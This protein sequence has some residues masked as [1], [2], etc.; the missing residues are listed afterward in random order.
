M[1]ADINMTEKKMSAREKIKL[2]HT[3]DFHLDSPFS[4]LDV[5]RSDERRVQL[6]E[7]FCAAVRRAKTD[8]CE[9]ILISGDLFDCGYVSEETVATVFDALA[10]CQIPTVISPGNHDP[11]TAGGVYSKK[12]LPSNVF[13][14]SSTELSYF[15]R[16]DLGVRVYGYAFVSEKYGEDPLSGGVSL[17]ERMI[18]ILC[19]HGDIY[20]PISTYASINLAQLEEIGFDYVALGHIHKHTEP[21]RLGKTVVSY[22]G[23]P[24]G[25]SF[26]EC[27]FGGALEVTVSH[28]SPSLT[29]NVEVKRV[30]LSDRRYLSESLDVSG[31]ASR[32][33]VAERIREYVKESA[34]GEETSLRLTLV[35]NVAPS[36]PNDI[37]MSADELG[38]S[39]ID[40]RNDTLPIFDA[41]YLESD[42]TLRGALYR[43]LLPQMR[44]PNEQERRIA[45]EALR[46]G[47]AALEGRPI[48]Q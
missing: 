23:F 4:G 48:I 24:D 15:D 5:K 31:S 13:V 26:D 11:F 19:A 27:G 45:A 12:S 17:D 6:R 16:P 9:L 2:F 34:L 32:G 33:D 3:A 42:I 47:L 1:N 20:S 41:Q 18:N 21:L 43:Q 39:L 37:S 28:S 36:L 25:R 38:L 29:E 8:G 22:A 40:I 35:G 14:F 10:D 7:A 30:T 46:V 44:S